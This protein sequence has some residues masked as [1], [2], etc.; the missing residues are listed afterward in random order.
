MVRVY[1]PAVVELHETLATPELDRLLG[2]IGP[3]FRP[4]GKESVRLTVPMKPFR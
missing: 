2:E 4:A 1:V 3:Q